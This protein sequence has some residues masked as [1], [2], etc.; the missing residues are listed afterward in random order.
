MTIKFPSKY[1]LKNWKFKSKSNSNNIYDVELWKDGRIECNCPASS[2][3]KK[4]CKHKLQT[5]SELESF[6]GSI[7]GGIEYYAR[8]K[9]K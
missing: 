7:Q 5:I 6:F 3:K 1:P 4:K 9:R 2:F 8:E